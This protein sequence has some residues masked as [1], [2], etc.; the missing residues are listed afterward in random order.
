M[1]A[2]T[3]HSRHIEVQETPIGCRVEAM[4][5]KMPCERKEKK[6]PCHGLPC[7]RPRS[8][9]HWRTMHVIERQRKNNYK[10]GGKTRWVGSEAAILFLTPSSGRHPGALPQLGMQSDCL[11]FSFLLLFLFS[12]RSLPCFTLG[13]LT[14]GATDVIERQAFALESC[15]ARG[16]GKKQSSSLTPNMSTPGPIH[17]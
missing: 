17:G 10:A 7:S 2:L 6:N 8:C 3:H 9:A 11:W 12:L 13:A 4:A 16:D 1:H 14:S 15:I 5:L